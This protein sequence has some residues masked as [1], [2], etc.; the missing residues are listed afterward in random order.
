MNSTTLPPL[1]PR[2]S[3]QTSTKLYGVS[4]GGS[5][6]HH[7]HQHHHNHHSH[8]QT[9][10]ANLNSTI[11]TSGIRNGRGSSSSGG[12]GGGIQVQ[13]LYDSSTTMPISSSNTKSA[14]ISAL[15]KNAQ[16]NSQSMLPANTTTTVKSPSA[17]SL[18]SN[19]SNFNQHNNK[20]NSQMNMMTAMMNSST[21]SSNLPST[22]QQLSS[23]AQQRRLSSNLMTPEYAM[24]T[25]M[26]KLTSFEHHEIFN[27]PEIY[28]VG[29]SAKKIA[30]VT[31][32]PNNNGY[33][34]ENGSYKPVQHDQILY[35][36]AII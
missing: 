3:N 15:Q 30:G 5:V 11:A 12:G 24:K 29:Q 14:Y 7:H 25:Y 31:G 17:E 2:N 32:G 19:K 36:L 18:V 27:Y 6:G 22:T 34:D 16:H 21:I 4:G 8:H 13:Q 28:F 10:I 1:K 9:N 26:S 20:H 33:D 23:A 35:R